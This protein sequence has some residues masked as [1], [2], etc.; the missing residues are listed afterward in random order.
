MVWFNQIMKVRKLERY[1]WRGERDRHTYRQT[2]R[3]TESETEGCIE[4]SI[5]H[6][7]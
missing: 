5:A 7:P 6:W 3:E 1:Y 2:D 4:Y